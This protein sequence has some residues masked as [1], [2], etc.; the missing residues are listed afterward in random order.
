MTANASNV[1]ETT[2]REKSLA[3]FENARGLFKRDDY[4]LALA[5]I[6]RA[7]ALVPNDSLMHEFRTLPV[8]PA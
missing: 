4:P 8:C 3:I 1:G 2:N 6:N 5:E 7:V